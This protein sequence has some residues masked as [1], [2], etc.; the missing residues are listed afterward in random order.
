MR[1]R[2]LFLG[3][4]SLTACLLIVGASAQKNNGLNFISELEDYR[5]IRDALP[6]YL[7]RLVAAKLEDRKRTIDRLKSP[8]DVA[9]RREKVRARILESI[10]GL[11]ERTPLNARVVG[12]I[13]RAEYRIEKIIFESQPR[14]FVTANLYI[15]KNGRRP[16][17]GI[18]V[19]LGHEPAPKAYPD[20]QALLEGLAQRGFAA[21]AWD[22]IGQGERVQ[23]YDPDLGESKVVRSPTEHSVV[24]IQCTVV[25]DNLARY[26]IQ[27][28]LQALNYLLTRPEVDPARIGCTG[29]S[30]GGNLTAYLA[31]LDD[32]IQVAA[33]SCWITSW[34]GLL[35]T[36]GP[37]DSEQTLFPF[38]KDEIDYP[39][40]IYAFA[41]KPYLVLAA[42]RDF[43]S[44]GGTRQTY[45]EAKSIY[46]MLGEPSKLMMFEADDHHA[47]SAPRRLAAYR[48]FGRWLKGAEDPGQESE[49]KV[50]L[51][52]DEE[53]RC[54]ET[55]QVTTSLNSET[56]FSLNQKRADAFR[57]QRLSAQS[58][59]SHPAFQAEIRRRIS[60]SIDF[61]P[62]KG[63][64]PPVKSYG[65]IDNSGYRVEKFI[66]ESE[67]GIPIPSLLFIPETA[68]ARKPAILYVHGR[69]K[70]AGVGD[71]ED[72]VKA[73]FVVLAIDV[74][75]AG[76]TT[77]LE[78]Q[79][80]NDTRPYFGDFDSSMI[81]L[82]LGRPLAGMRAMDVSRG[83]DFL[84][85][86]GEVDPGRI[87][88]FGK[89]SG[90]IPLLFAATL[91]ER[92]KKVALEGM[93]VSYQS[94]ITR[95]IHRQIF[96][97]LVPGALKL[98]DFP[99]L[100]A[101]LAPRPTW[102]VN[103]VDPIG[104]PIDLAEMKGA[105]FGST[106]SFRATGTENS[107]RIAIRKDQDR[108]APFYRDWLEQ[109]RGRTQ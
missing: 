69:G 95:R 36:I 81:A 46:S 37:Q 54:T 27:D 68:E 107:I 19:P 91:D 102:V 76:E 106:T 6:S 42:T 39:D 72:L 79:Q 17:P 2:V 104:H 82:L 9:R 53:L 64:S 29:N 105:Y 62:A 56:V 83:V 55:G 26:M 1:I 92:I 47:Y 57:V 70:A 84:S 28:G 43:F 63:A 99:D 66:Y 32:R 13:E 38:I 96:E 71:I 109:T 65:R 34:Q 41:P 24:G 23:I 52:T 4:T 50:E 78:S 58:R 98:Y 90:A 101:A 25:G 67:P 103:S 86:R 16:Y 73:G 5:T 31:A 93:L 89:E 85:A 87:Y 80:S 33:P 59:D 30:G 22:P 12:T 61:A 40:F 45:G 44:I 49:P 11:P 74:R 60:Q 51:A 108:M 35:N 97:N 3:I 20:A 8:D 88:G 18:L 21:L 94:I 14:F 15:P 75:G 7:N 100:L 10:G 77:V 48:W